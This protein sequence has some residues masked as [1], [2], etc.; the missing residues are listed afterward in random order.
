LKKRKKPTL[1]GLAALV[2]T[3]LSGERMDLA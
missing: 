1:T 2:H 3:T